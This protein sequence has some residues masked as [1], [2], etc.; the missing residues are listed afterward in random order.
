MQQ[1]VCSIVWDGMPQLPAIPRARNALY[2]RSGP[3]RLVSYTPTPSAKVLQ[4]I[5]VS[6]AISTGDRL[7]TL[8]GYRP[9]VCR[10]ELSHTPAQDSFCRGKLATRIPAVGHLQSPALVGQSGQ[11]K[12][13]I[14]YHVVVFFRGVQER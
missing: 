5:T 12:W 7:S 3:P 1:P 10:C 11:A 13:C 8:R 6:L 9:P 2:R 4:P 14:M